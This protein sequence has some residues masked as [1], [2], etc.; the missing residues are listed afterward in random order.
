MSTYDFSTLY[1]KDKL[2]ELIERTFN[3]ERSPYLVGND[4]NGFFTMENK[5]KHIM[6]G[7]VKF[8]RR[9]DLL[10]GNIFIRFGT[11]VYR[12]EVGVPM[13]TNWLPRLPIYSCFVMRGTLQCLFMTISSLILLI[14]LTQHP[15]IWTMIHLIPKLL[16]DL[17]LSISYDIVLTKIYDKRGDFDFPIF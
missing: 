8:V 3:R 16:V 13:G 2:I 17:H 6:H 15:D 1:I 12:Q 11:K 4:R 7:L 10:L 14:L 5:K 9:S